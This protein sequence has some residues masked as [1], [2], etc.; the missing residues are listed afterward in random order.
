VYESDP[1]FI[2]EDYPGF[3]DYI[4]KDLK[5]DGWAA[6][7]PILAEYLQDRAYA[8]ASVKFIFDNPVYF[9]RAIFRTF[10]NTWR[11]DYPDKRVLNKANGIV[12]GAGG[13]PFLFFKAENLVFYVGM[14]PF[15]IF[16]VYISIKNR[17]TQALSII[18]FFAYFV[19]VHSVFAS[20]IRYR[21]IV[22]P[23]FFILSA[24]GLIEFWNRVK[25]LS[26]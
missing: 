9:F 11:A 5:L 23:L 20:M 24:F 19:I 2:T 16:G 21:I 1:G 18:L 15:F 13:I 3:Q 14:I 4:E 26:K 25:S 8:R 17:N 7:S 6:T 10:W 12:S 22:M